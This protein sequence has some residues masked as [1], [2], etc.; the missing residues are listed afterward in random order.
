MR[1]G[2]DACFI[3]VPEMGRLAVETAVQVLEGQTVLPEISVRIELITQDNLLE[4]QSGG[5]Q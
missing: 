1:N 4:S 5:R 2:S 3:R